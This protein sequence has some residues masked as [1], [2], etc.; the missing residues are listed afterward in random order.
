MILLS[1]K[2]KEFKRKT[3]P[4]S[5]LPLI[6]KFQIPHSSISLPHSRFSFLGFEV[7][8]RCIIMRALT[9]ITIRY[10]PFASLFENSVKPVPSL[11]GS[12]LVAL[13]CR[14]LVAMSLVGKSSRLRL[15]TD[16]R[17]HNQHPTLV[18]PIQVQYLVAY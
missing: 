7:G 18:S 9:R 14:A 11:C 15:T 10:D 3:N 17:L 1:G 4:E 2:T 6:L 5:R 13:D 12:V 16:M 8:V